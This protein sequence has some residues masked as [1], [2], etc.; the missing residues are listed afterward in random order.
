[1]Q[2]ALLAYDGSF[3]AQEALFIAAY[4]AAKWNIPLSVISIGKVDDTRDIQD[5][6]RKYLELH[7]I[8]ADYIPADGE[9]SA[10][11]ILRYA[12]M[13]KTDLL[14]IGGYSRNPILEVLQGGDV[15]EL[16]RQTGIPVI[17]CR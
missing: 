7:N 3:K 10:D 16:L 1:M 6:A 11:I 9:N 2:H 14:L 5:D 13:Q 4:L 8:Q 17:I 15:D 12:D